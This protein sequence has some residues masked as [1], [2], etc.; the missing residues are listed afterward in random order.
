MPQQM[1]ASPKLPGGKNA[2]RSSGAAPELPDAD[3]G[4]G[5]LITK[6]IAGIG[7]EWN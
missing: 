2:H 4:V 1:P 7:L 5:K 3:P 6:K